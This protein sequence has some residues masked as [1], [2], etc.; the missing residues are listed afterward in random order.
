MKY[1][2]HFSVAVALIGVSLSASA[3]GPVG[4]DTN[5]LVNGD[6]ESGSFGWDLAPMDFVTS[7]AG[8]KVLVGFDLA[9]CCSYQ[10]ITTDIG[11]KY[12]FSFDYAVK[13]GY[14]GGVDA[15]FGSTNVLDLASARNGGFIHKSYTV[16]ADA[17]YADV[18]FGLGRGLMLDNVSVTAVPEPTTA[19]LM[20]L[21]L[22]GLA[23][24]R[25]R[26]V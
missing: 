4:G 1:V 24:R 25:A 22:A 19:A 9:F 3:V 13:P 2:K 11:K 16:T 8:G 18:R 12:N 14:G 21:G 23:L 5:L 6:F 15:N 17:T 20:A 7:N 26:K 10:R